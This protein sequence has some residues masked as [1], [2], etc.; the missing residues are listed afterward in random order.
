MI[1]TEAHLSDETLSERL[2]DRLAAGA[3]QRVDSHLA[4]CAECAARYAG[5]RVTRAALRSLR[6]VEL[7]RDFR[8]DFATPLPIAS[9]RPTI[10]RSRVGVGR[11]LSAA[12]LLAGLFL[13]VVGL[14]NLV[15]PSIEIHSEATSAAP[16]VSNTA[17]GTCVAGKGCSNISVGATPTTSVGYSPVAKTPQ[18]NAAA[19]ATPSPTLQSGSS[20]TVQPVTPVPTSVTPSPLLAVVLGLLVTLAG[21]VGLFATRPRP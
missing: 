7:P 15:L 18:S 13:F 1:P 12:V 14:V 2:D 20:V 5:L 9:R 3:R 6:R 16:S 17:S 21:G 4:G 8:L 10:L 11:F 19:E